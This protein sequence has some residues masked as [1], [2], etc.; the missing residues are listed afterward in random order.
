MEV[1]GNLQPQ[2]A[3]KRL[4]LSRKQLEEGA[5]VELVALLEDITADGKVAL[6]EAEQL[7][8]WINGAAGLDFPG[9][10]YLRQILEH[11]LEDEVLTS[12]E[13]KVLYGAIEKVLPP[14]SKRPDLAA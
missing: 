9:V 4:S 11:V 2:K 8:K 14:E 10:E 7:R 5:A 13:H 12:E 3:P 6:Q 1:D